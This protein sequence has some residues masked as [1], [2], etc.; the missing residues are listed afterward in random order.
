MPARLYKYVIRCVDHVGKVRS[1]AWDNHQPDHRGDFLQGYD[2]EFM[3]GAGLATW[4]P[5]PTH[6]LAFPTMTSAKNL[7]MTS[8]RSKP[9]REDGK[10]NRP[11]TAYTLEIISIEKAIQE[12]AS[13]RRGPESDGAA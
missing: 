11:L 1:L 9:T 6:A 2:P 4:T 10:P 5:D 3:N 12:A 7:I 13:A 8:P